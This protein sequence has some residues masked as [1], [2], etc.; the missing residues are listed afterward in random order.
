MRDAIRNKMRD[1]L[2]KTRGRERR[3]VRSDKRGERD[4]MR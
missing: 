1:K 4:Q 2:T 3:R